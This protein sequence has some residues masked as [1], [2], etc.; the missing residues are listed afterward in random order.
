MENVD[1]Q[2]TSKV[3]QPPISSR[4]RR[5][6]S[7]PIFLHPLNLRQSLQRLNHTK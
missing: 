5:N 6:L 2:E 3:F 1:L 7:N 4:F